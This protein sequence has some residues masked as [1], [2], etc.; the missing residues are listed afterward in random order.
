MKFHKTFSTSIFPSST[1][2]IMLG[3]NGS[4]DANKY[5]K[6]KALSKRILFCLIVKQ[7]Y[8]IFF[9]VGLLKVFNRLMCIVNF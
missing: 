9:T 4:R 6:K 1:A 7:R 5:V 8:P 2:E 3:G